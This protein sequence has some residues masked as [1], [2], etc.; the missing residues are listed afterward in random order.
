MTTLVL[1]CGSSSVKYA[2]FDGEVVLHRHQIDRSDGVTAALDELAARPDAVGHRLVHGGPAHSRPVRIDDTVLASL[3]E[4]IPFAPLHL[5]VELAAITAVK[6]RFGDVPQVACFDT[7]FH[8]RMPEVARRFALPEPL[9][10]AGV[11]RYGFHGLSYEYIASVVPS[12]PRA[13]Y[14]H[15]GNGAS[16]VAVRDGI[17]IDTTMGFTPT[18]GL[19]M[20][21][22]S[23]DLDPGVLLYLLGR[24]YDHR[25]LAKLVDHEAG[26]LALSGTTSDMRALLAARAT[27]PRAA[28]A[29][30]VFCY[31]AKKALGGFV[32]VLGGIETLVFTGGIGESAAEVRREICAGLAGFGIT[33]DPI[34]NAAN[35]PVVSL[36]S[37]E[38][39]VIMTDE[40]A[41]IARHTRA[42]C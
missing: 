7:A 16:M 37:C 42:L 34:R 8:Q 31:H 9:F 18:G 14:A 3:H 33:L 19:V 13:V 36:G 41:V 4:A 6:Q 32:A 35:A 24:G 38:V 11:R 27:D 39:R 40:A 28:L 12:R 25:S 30:D 1:N 23:G 17:S 20:G 26:L 15:L 10:A 21:T 2:L 5:P 22:R 29:V